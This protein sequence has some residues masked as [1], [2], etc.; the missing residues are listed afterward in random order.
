MKFNVGDIII[1]KKEWLDPGETAEPVV[2]LDIWHDDDLNK[3]KISVIS[4]EEAKAIAKGT[5]VGFPL[6]RMDT[7]AEYYDLV[8]KYNE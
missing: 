1:P 8:E 4:V 2:V 3:D 7:F 5:L 6:S